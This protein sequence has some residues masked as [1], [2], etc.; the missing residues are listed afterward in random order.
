MNFYTIEF[1]GHKTRIRDLVSVRVKA[2][3]A[4]HYFQF[5]PQARRLCRIA[6][7]GFAHINFSRLTLPVAINAADIRERRILYTPAIKELNFIS[8]LKINSGV[9]T[10]RQHHFEF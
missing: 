1:D 4:E 7:W 3:C 9:R 5:L 2:R 8:P 6:Q 10:F